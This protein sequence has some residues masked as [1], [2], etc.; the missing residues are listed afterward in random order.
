MHPFVLLLLLLSHVTSSM[1]FTASRNDVCG[2][3][4]TYCTLQHASVDQIMYLQFYTRSV[5]VTWVCLGA[6][7]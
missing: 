5:H 1:Y 7:H 4:N 3:L 6:H 2:P